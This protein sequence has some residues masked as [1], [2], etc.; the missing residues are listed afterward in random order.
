MKIVEQI[1]SMI[2]KLENIK[3]EA[4]K[5]QD[6]GVNSVA[7]KVNK[8]MM[9]IKNDTKLVKSEISEARRIAKEQK[10]QKV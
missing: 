10:A 5:F 9:E 3:T 1:N 4:I 7:T 8:V 2:E 6:K